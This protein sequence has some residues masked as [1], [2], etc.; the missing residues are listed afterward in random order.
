MYQTL[1]LILICIIFPQKRQLF[2]NKKSKYFYII[3]FSVPEVKILILS[4][5]FILFGTMGLINFSINIRD[6]D[7]I[8]DRLLDYF[9]CQAS[10]YSADHTCSAE[11]ERF[12]THLQLELN[13]TTY[14]L[15]GLLPWFNLLFAVQ[16]SDIKKAMQ[17]VLYFCHSRDS[18]NKTL[19]A[20]T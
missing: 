3:S 5:Y 7:I 15:L 16:V 12:R 2:Q 4:C 1:A 19:S 14:A 11:Y 6:A 18:K 20:S 17:K 9:A 13:S 8:L 10:G